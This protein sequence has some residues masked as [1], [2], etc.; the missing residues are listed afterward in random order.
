MI[1]APLLFF[2]A[3]WIVKVNGGFNV[4]SS[5]ATISRFASLPGILQ[6]KTPSCVPLFSNSD[7]EI[8]DKEGEAQ[9][10]P[11]PVVLAVQAVFRGSYFL[12]AYAQIGLGIALSFGLLLNICGYAYTV[13]WKD[14]LVVD[15]IQ[16]LREEQQ[17]QK[18]AYG[19][20][21][22]SDRGLTFPQSQLLEHEKPI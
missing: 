18:A 10:E 2:L 5:K 19:Y 14:G 11:N 15:T 7:D 21:A 22:P 6:H 3:S 4:L 1:S 13:S 17:F 16:K 20:E 8:H 12:F 9:P